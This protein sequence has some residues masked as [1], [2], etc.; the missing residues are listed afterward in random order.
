MDRSHR[1]QRLHR[2]F[3]TPPKN[4]QTGMISA[5]VVEYRAQFAVQIDG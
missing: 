2:R 5:Y 4:A 1:D 3:T